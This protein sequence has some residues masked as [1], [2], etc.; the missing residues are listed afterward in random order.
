MRWMGMLSALLVLIA[1]VVGVSSLTAFGFGGWDI[2]VILV[3]MAIG[4]ALFVWGVTRFG[5]WT[6]R[7]LNRS[8]SDSP[9]PDEGPQGD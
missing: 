3:P 4:V 9:G 8:E 1:V 5:V 7:M 2:V 6:A